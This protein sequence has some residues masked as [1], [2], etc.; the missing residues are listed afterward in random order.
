MRIAVTDAC[1][2]IDLLELT[3]ASP[4]FDLNIEVHTTLDVMNELYPEQQAVLTA[5]QSVRK[6]TVHT[7]SAED[8]N[9]IHSSTFPKALSQQDKSVIYL[10]AQ[11]EAMVLSSDKAV[12]SFVQ[13][14]AVETHGMFWIFDQLV[15]QELLAKDAAISKLSQL[16]NDNLMY[17]NNTRLRR[18]ADLRIKRWSS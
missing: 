12:R 13:R 3:L 11:L 6:L 16:M 4:F 18:E 17:R 8:L 9:K 15:S 7:L 1:V 2:F 14:A 10:A 5:Y